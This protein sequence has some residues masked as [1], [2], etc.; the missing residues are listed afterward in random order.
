MRKFA[1]EIIGSLLCLMLGMLSGLSVR[2]SDMMWYA[3]L[4]KPAFNPPTWLFGPVWAVL[5]I[6]MGIALAKIYKD[7]NNKALFIFAVQFVLNIIWTPLFFYMQRIDLALIDIVLLWSCLIVFF[8]CT[9]KNS[10]VIMLFIPY[11]LWT[12]FAMILTLSLY[13]LN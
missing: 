1:P 3:N 4:H 10:T 5:Y 2:I 9:R 12:T 7:R 11:A 8:I 13:M 6:M